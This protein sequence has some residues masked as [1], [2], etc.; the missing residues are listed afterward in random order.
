VAK[1]IWVILLIVC[2]ACV[3]LELAR[4]GSS[5]SA[6]VRATQSYL[7]AKHRLEKA[8]SAESTARTSAF[9][10]F[11]DHVQASCANI[12]AGAPKGGGAVTQEAVSALDYAGR[13]VVRPAYLS[14]AKVVTKLRWSSRKLTRLVHQQGRAAIAAVSIVQP[15]VCVDA[16]RF[17]ASGYAIEPASTKRFLTEG[18]AVEDEKSVH[19]AGSD[20]AGLEQTIAGMLY[21]YERPSERILLA[22]PSPSLTA[23]KAFFAALNEVFRAL[24]LSVK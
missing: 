5:A 2:L 15:D 12:L 13:L 10:I 24:G 3:G 14:F 6:N 19:E 4:S 21:P 7:I 8:I 20:E 17:V 18:M 11:V 1:R 16:K 9:Q 23:E 22:P